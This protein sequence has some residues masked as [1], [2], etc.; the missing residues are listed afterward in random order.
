MPGVGEAFKRVK[1]E[2]K[3]LS[4]VVLRVPKSKADVVEKKIKESEKFKKGGQ[5]APIRF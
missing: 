4:S 3:S 2:F 5:K 1:E